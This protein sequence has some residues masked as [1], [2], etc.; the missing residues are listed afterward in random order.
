MLHAFLCAYFPENITAGF[1]EPPQP[2]WQSC[3]SRALRHNYTGPFNPISKA[4]DNSHGHIYVKQEWR[5]E[6][7]LG[8]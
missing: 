8:S 2:S 6:V 4:N 3:V 7:I 1:S 5:W